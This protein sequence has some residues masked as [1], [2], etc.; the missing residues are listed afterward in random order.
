MIMLIKINIFMPY[1]AYRSINYFSRNSKVVE[2]FT[3]NLSVNL[4][5]YFNVFNAVIMSKWYLLTYLPCPMSHLKGNVK[6]SIPDNF[7]LHSRHSIPFPTYIRE[8]AKMEMIMRHDLG[9]RI[10]S[11]SS[12]ILR[13]QSGEDWADTLVHRTNQTISYP[14]SK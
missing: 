9:C 11:L 5:K 2:K 14:P 13:A 3:G 6:T 8:C 4:N 1:K 7:L 12:S 10:F